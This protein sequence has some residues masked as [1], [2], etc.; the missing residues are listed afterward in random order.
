MPRLAT[1]LRLPFAGCFA[2]FTL[3]NAAAAETSGPVDLPF[4][5]AGPFV[6]LLLAIALLPILAAHWWH[7]NRNRA[8]VAALFAVPV[9][10]YLVYVQLATG[11]QT[12][13]LLLHEIE[14]YAYFIILL[15]SLYTV[16]GGIV[17]RANLRARPL[18]NTALLALGA[19]LANAI[20]T[21]GASVLL[22]RPVLHINRAREHAAHLPVFF[23]FI[24]SNLG[25]LL[26]P[27]GDPPL[28][29]GFLN[30]VPF[31]WTLSLWPQ[32]L[33]TNGVVLAIFLIWDTLACRREC[34]E[35]IAGTLGQVE[36]LRLEGLP[37]L[38][39]LAGIIAGIML[40]GSLSSPWGNAGGAL[41]MVLM[42]V[43]SLLLTPRKLRA[44]NSFTWG[45]ILEVAILFAGIFV[46]MVPALEVLSRHGTDF[47]LTRP[48]QYFWLTGLLSGFLDN[49]PTYL[50]FGTLAAG[51]KD[52]NLLIQ[53]QAAGLNGPLV[54][55]AISC[56]AVFMGALTYIG[57]G[58]NFMVKAIADE[59]GLRTPSFLG[60][61]VYSCLV[62]L[63]VFVVVSAL[64]FLRT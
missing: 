45:P 61:L 27:L 42:G 21:A 35:V 2:H 63:P 29:L 13:P 4:W 39:F 50:T 31:A 41:L 46:T 51:S 17:L 12:I 49:A 19:V 20:G 60:Y 38:L 5:S 15:I 37:N 57:N 3:P 7:H 62:L 64:F 59:A 30:G 43:L 58:P 53:D 1:P 14:D 36:P 6:L 18:T 22:I 11:Q 9:A 55:Q 40:Q 28:F 32:W 8:L 33:F 54:L 52:F 34:P 25:G 24:V 16:A 23:I 47:G 10:V 56:G 26:T 48:W 44:A